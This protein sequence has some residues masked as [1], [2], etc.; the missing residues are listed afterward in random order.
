MKHADI[1]RPALVEFNRHELA[2]LGAPCGVIQQL[3]RNL[4]PRLTAL[5]VGYVDA[6]HASGNDAP[7]GDSLVTL[8]ATAVLTDKI[9]YRNLELAQAPDRFAQ[10][11][12]LAAYSLVLVNGNHFRAQ[13]QIAIID[14]R[15]PLTR[16]LDR[17]TDVQLILLAEGESELP[18][19][20]LSQRPELGTVPVLQLTDTAAIAQWVLTWWQARQPP[21]RGLVLAGG[22]S[23]RMGTDKSRLRYHGQSQREYAAELLAPHCQ[24]VFISGQPT[25]LAD[26]P[27]PWR[28]L[29]DRFL[30]LGPMSGLLSA[31]CHNP[32]AA[33]LA[34]GCDLPFLTPAT[35]ARL[36]ESRNS[37]RM[38]TTFHSAATGFP[39]PLVTIWEPNAYSTLLRFLSL[40]YSCPRKVLINSD[41]AVIQPIDSAELRNVN[42]PDERAKAEQE[43]S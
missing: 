23:R 34:V 5:R 8:G 40:G 43:I 36:V 35:I 39:E 37:A 31:F 28:P 25:Q 19:D 42:T 32:N 3:V 13:Q 27:A 16:K 14:A 24:E 22:A 2:I 17:L 20:L 26:L 12:W 30:N 29:P 1:P 4:I 15:K 18:A 7:S 9:H 11:N 6:D 10:L 21:L 38:A 33:W 41:V